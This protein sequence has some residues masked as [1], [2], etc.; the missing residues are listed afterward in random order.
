MQ[1]NKFRYRP[2]QHQPH[3]D[4]DQPNSPIP[5]PL[6]DIIPRPGQ[7]GT[8]TVLQT[9]EEQCINDLVVDNPK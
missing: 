3:R 1:E 9:G 6:A 8:L 5:P 2:N 4:K 7:D